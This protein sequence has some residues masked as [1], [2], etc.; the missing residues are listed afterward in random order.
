MAHLLQPCT[1]VSVLRLQLVGL[2]QRAGG[3]TAEWGTTYFGVYD[4]AGQAGNCSSYPETG[5]S[6]SRWMSLPMVYWGPVTEQAELQ[7]IGDYIRRDAYDTSIILVGHCLFGLLE[8]FDCGLLVSA[9]GCVPYWAALNHTLV[10]FDRR[11]LH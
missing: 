9:D 5:A 1:S 11:Y 10:T 8:R 7:H 2:L 4:V 6:S 3:D